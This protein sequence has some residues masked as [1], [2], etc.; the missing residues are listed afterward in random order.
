MIYNGDLD[1]ACDHLGDMWFTEDLGQPV[2]S[3]LIVVHYDEMDLHQVVEGFK[4]WH[5]IDHM[6]Y[7]QIAGFVLQYENLKF[8][9]VKV[10][11][12]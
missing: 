9:S 12:M 7:P 8:V 10:S 6:G 5:Y 11:V 2:S 1:M 4:D 3:S